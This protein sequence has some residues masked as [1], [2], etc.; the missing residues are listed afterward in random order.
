MSQ[1]EERLAAL[2]LALPECPVPVAAYVPSVEVGG[3]V[4]ASGQTP[5]VDGKLIYKGKLGREFGIEQGYDAAKLAALRVIAELK[6]AVGDLDRIERIVKVTGYVNSAEDF[7][8]QP[9]VVNGAS[10]LMRSAFGAK[11]EHARVAFGVAALPDGAAVEI[12]AIAWVK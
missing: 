8:D 3:F 5:V 4:F 7:E 10:E 2:G 1:V 6:A 11:G 9:K 12:D